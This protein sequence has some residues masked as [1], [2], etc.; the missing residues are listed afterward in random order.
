MKKIYLFLALCLM[1]AMSMRAY[2]PCAVT[3]SGDFED[4]VKSQLTSG[5]HEGRDY[6]YFAL[7]T[8]DAWYLNEEHYDELV[9][10]DEDGMAFLFPIYAENME[11]VAGMY[12]QGGVMY[13]KVNGK[14]DWYEFHNGT[15]I[16][17]VNE[18]GTGYDL[19][20]NLTVEGVEYNGTVAGVCAEIT[21]TPEPEPIDPEE[22]I[23]DVQSN[24]V[25]S[26]KVIRDGMLLIQRNGKTLN[27][28]GAEVK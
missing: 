11:N 2:E 25:Q 5:Q 7:F 8:S 3:G 15:I 18:E 6:L 12:T 13:S 27:V 14:L 1:S 10:G 20:L 28:L 21:L 19:V 23:E 24:K 9:T 26:K 17:S 16:I 22:G 4:V